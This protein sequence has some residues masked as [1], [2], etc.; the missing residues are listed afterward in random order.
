MAD[1]SSTATADEVIEAARSAGFRVTHDQLRRWHLAGALPRPTQTSLGRPFG[2]VTLYPAEAKR[3]VVRLCQLHRHEKRLSHIRWALWWE[4]YAIDTTVAR[5]FLAYV[6]G[7]LDKTL[8]KVRWLL[9]DDDAANVLFEKSIT[10]RISHALVRQVRKRVGRQ[11]FPQVMDLILRV[12]IGSFSGYAL[13]GD[14]QE[15]FEKGLGV[16]RARTDRMYLAPPWLQDSEE[17]LVRLSALLKNASFTSTLDGADDRELEEA[18]GELRRFMTLMDGFGQ[19]TGHRFGRGAFGMI[20]FGVGKHLLGIEDYARQCLLW[21]HTR[22]SDDM[23]RGMAKIL[24]AEPLVEG[25]IRSSEA[26]DVLAA[27]VPAFARLVTPSRMR[28]AARSSKTH[29]AHQR[30]L[31]AAYEANRDAV[32]AFKARHPDLILE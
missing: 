12:S 17:P 2:T 16:D 8:S 5:S 14:E 25:L 7:D 18:R 24:E 6:A 21:L 27:E 9:A 4:G 13:Y 11:R 32:E 15:V 31:Q 23:Q 22:R 20:L 30:Q 26:M 19:A 10:T 29:E 3:Q 28:A 1:E